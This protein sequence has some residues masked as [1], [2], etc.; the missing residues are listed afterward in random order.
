MN[1]QDNK[2]AVSVLATLTTGIALIYTMIMFH[3]FLFAVV[4]MSI[5]F[6]ITAFILTKNLITFCTVKNKSLNVQI[7]S[8]IDDIS[9]QLETMNGAQSQIGKA[10]YLYTRQTAKAVTTLEN[11][12]IESQNTLYKNL[13]SLANIQSKA[14]KLMIKYNQNNTNNVISSIKD[15]NSKINTTIIHGF[16]QIQPDHIE[17]ISILESI[18]N[19]LKEQSN[20]LNPDLGVQ[21]QNIACEL[22]NISNNIQNIQITVQDSAQ[23]APVQEPLT[24]GVPAPTEAIYD[25]TDSIIENEIATDAMTAEEN[26]S[27]TETM[28][29]PTDI[30]TIEEDASLAEVIDIPTDTTTTEDH[31]SL[32]EVIHFTTDSPQPEMTDN[33]T[34]SIPSENIASVTDISVSEEAEETT[35]IFSEQTTEPVPDKALNDMLSADEIAAL[36]AAAEPAPKKESKPKAAETPSAATQKEVPTADSNA[37]LSPDEI[38]ALFA[39][40]G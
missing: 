39:S 8:C 15:M 7:K 36:F 1:K 25:S 9:S 17:L 3:D 30:A 10:T 32:T 34:D 4:G 37:T 31:T 19:A 14:T 35:N 40:M 13:A 23:Y 12:Y 2:L 11:N 22:E 26:I 24:E 21:L 6:L 29:I 20:E 28:D 38:A 5:L 18:V 16:D 33:A 27:L